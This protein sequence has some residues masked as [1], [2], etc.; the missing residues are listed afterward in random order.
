DDLD[1]AI[2]DD[3]GRNVRH[4]P[5][6]VPKH[7]SPFL[8]PEAEEIFAKALAEVNDEGIIPAGFGVAEAEWDDGIYSEIEVITV[9]RK[10]SE[11]ALPFAIWWPRAVSWTQGLELM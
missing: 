3:Q 6:D 11:V 2:A 5:I 10:D 1:T 9:G 4:E 8:T 7:S